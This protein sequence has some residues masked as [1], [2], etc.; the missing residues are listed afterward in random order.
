[1]GLHPLHSRRSIS[2]PKSRQRMAEREAEAAKARVSSTP[3]PVDPRSPVVENA[4]IPDAVWVVLCEFMDKI[5]TMFTEVY[6][7]L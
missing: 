7:F 5:E 4:E 3:S 1:M 2:T 6:V